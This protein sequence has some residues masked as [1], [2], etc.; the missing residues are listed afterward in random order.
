VVISF[1]GLLARP[2]GNMTIGRLHCRSGT[3]D[4][5]FSNPSRRATSNLATLLLT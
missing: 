2:T 4:Q 5:P 1:I 3:E